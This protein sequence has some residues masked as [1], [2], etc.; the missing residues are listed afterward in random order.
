MHATGTDTLFI[1]LLLSI[2]TFLSYVYGKKYIFNIICHKDWQICGRPQRSP[3]ICIETTAFFRSPTDL[4]R[5]RDQADAFCRV[6]NYKQPRTDTE[7]SLDSFRVCIVMD[8][9]QARAN[10]DRQNDDRRR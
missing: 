2:F 4:R 6:G 1:A 8:F 7:F 3:Y 9:E 10:I 5:L